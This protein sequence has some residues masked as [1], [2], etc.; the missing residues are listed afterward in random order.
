MSNKGEKILLKLKQQ[1]NERQEE[2][3]SNKANNSALYKQGFI[4]QGK[5]NQSITLIWLENELALM[6]QNGR[7]CSLDQSPR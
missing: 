5:H 6:E 2:R 1:S 3:E 4:K 7:V